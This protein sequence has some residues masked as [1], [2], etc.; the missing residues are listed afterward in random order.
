MFK[1]LLPSLSLLFCCGTCGTTGMRVQLIIV[2]VC[3]YNVSKGEF[4]RELNIIYIEHFLAHA[5]NIFHTN[6]YNHEL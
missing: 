4:K 1:E 2:Y 6:S 3:M 5:R